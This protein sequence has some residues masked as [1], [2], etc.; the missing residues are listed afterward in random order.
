MKAVPAPIR[1]LLALL[2]P[3]LL[4]P[5]FPELAYPVFVMKVLCYALFALA[6]N[7]LIG[8]T[9]LVSFGHAAFFGWA[10]YTTGILMIRLSAV[11]LP[12][13]LAIVAGVAV[14]IAIGWVIGSL[15]IRRTGIYFAMITLALSQVAY[16]LAVQIGWTGGEDGMQGIPRGR[17]LGFIDLGVDSHMY[18]F[19]LA[20]FVAGFLAV[21]RIVNS[22]F[23]QALKALRDNEPRAT[24]LGYDTDRCKLYAFM[25]SAGLAGLAGSLK[26]LVLQL[27][28]LNDVMLSTSTEVLLMTLLGGLGT[29]WGPVVGAALVVSLQNHL[30][31]LG[32]VVTIIIGLTFIVC[33]SFFRRGLVGELQAWLR[34][35]PRTRQDNEHRPEIL[36]SPGEQASRG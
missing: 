28:S 11:G 32:G 5:A 23:G 20:V 9:G 35:R 10:G 36:G 3:A 17:L 25:L 7:L 2:L 8:F 33:V 24:S 1:I 22:P 29:S 13:E 31:A 16:F 15:A 19:T 6:F 14:A 18:Y 26:A 30:A 27:S 34:R 12:V 4:V 21:H